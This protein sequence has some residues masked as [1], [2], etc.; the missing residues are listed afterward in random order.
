MIKA[1]TLPEKA[2]RKMKRKTQIDLI[3]EDLWQ[4]INQG[5]PTF[6]FID[7]SYNYKHLAN[8]CRMPVYTVSMEMIE[9]KYLK[10][11]KTLPVYVPFS[12][13]RCAMRHIPY[14]FYIQIHHVTDEEGKPHVYGSIHPDGLEE[15]WKD[16]F[17]PCIEKLVAEKQLRMSKRTA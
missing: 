8:Y 3:T 14:D 9:R 16:K 12:D 10:Y 7:D 11:A 4:A 1:A 15:C 6:E 2:K 13:V 5:I 17:L